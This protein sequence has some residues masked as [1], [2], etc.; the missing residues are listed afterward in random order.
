MIKSYL[1][2]CNE[3]CSTKSEEALIMALVVMLRRV[4]RSL[5]VFILTP[6]SLA[7]LAAEGTPPLPDP[8]PAVPCTPL[9]T[10]GDW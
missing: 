4:A 6:S 10:E 1:F 8:P 3:A 5:T 2:P 7:T 9:D